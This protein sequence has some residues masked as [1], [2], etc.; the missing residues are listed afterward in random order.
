MLQCYVAEYIY[1]I[2]THPCTDLCSSAPISRQPK[3]TKLTQRHLN[4][5]T[6]PIHL[7]R[8]QARTDLRLAF[9][10]I[11][12][13]GKVDGLHTVVAVEQIVVVVDVGEVGPVGEEARV[14]TR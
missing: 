4:R 3:Q 7:G 12:L 8:L 1:F 6:E 13:V 9:L 10:R 11:V 2:R 5:V 14:A